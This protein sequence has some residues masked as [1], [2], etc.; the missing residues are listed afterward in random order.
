MLPFLL[1]LTSAQDWVLSVPTL[2]HVFFCPVVSFST[3][4]NLRQTGGKLVVLC[5]TA[6]CEAGD[7]NVLHHCGSETMTASCLTGPQ[8]RSTEWLT[9]MPSTMARDSLSRQGSVHFRLSS[10]AAEEEGQWGGLGNLGLL[11]PPL[12]TPCL[13]HCSLPCSCFLFSSYL[14]PH[15]PTLEEV[16]LLSGTRKSRIQTSCYLSQQCA[17]TSHSTILHWASSLC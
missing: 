7:W 5:Q 13:G 6:K 11:A 9:Q 2:P 17:V 16:S 4:R 15:V 14:K 10:K 1:P 12:P 3:L 8:W